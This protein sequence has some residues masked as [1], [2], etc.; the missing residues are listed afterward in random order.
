MHADMMPSVEDF[1]M[2]LVISL[3]EYVI[4]PHLQ[5]SMKIKIRPIHKVL[6]VL[7]QVHH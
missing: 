7:D 6:G 5:S 4:Y 2:L 1:L 3:L